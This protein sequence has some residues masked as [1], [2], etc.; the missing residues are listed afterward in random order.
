M[1]NE[2]LNKLFSKDEKD[3]D[4]IV[5]DDKTEEMVLKLNDLVIGYLFCKEGEWIF[6]YSDEFKSQNEYHKIIGFPQLDK[7]YKSKKLWPFFRIRIPGLKQPAIQEIIEKEGI[8]INE[9]D[10]LKRFG[11]TSISNPYELV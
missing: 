10:L 9:Y 11:K 2:M 6:K 7:E 5:P 1:I 4:L 3:A 8:D